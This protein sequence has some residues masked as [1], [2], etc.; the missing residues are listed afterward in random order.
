MNI[1]GDFYQIPKLR[2]MLKGYLVTGKEE[3]EPIFKPLGKGTLKFELLQLLNMD[4]LAWFVNLISISFMVPIFLLA[5]LK[6]IT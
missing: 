4:R 2:N 1:W 5:I 6:F 3:K